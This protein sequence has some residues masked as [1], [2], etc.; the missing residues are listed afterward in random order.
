MN[1]V[2]VSPAIIPPTSYYSHAQEVPAGSR[3][4]YLSG[5]IPVAPDGSCPADFASQARL[6]WRN[7]AAVLA[8]ADMELSD[9]VRVQ[10][11]VTRVEDLE[12]YRD[13][14]NE[15]VGSLRPA[16]TLLVV[17]R[18]GKPEWHVEIEAIAAKAL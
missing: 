13:I 1:N 11:F 15:I 12:A 16:H 3:T 17:A 7:L 8:A 18:L 10:A 5:Q 2:L 4:V 6:C 14:R 9:V